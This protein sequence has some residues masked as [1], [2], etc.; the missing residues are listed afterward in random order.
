MEGTAI[1]LSDSPQ[2]IVDVMYWYDCTY[3]SDDIHYIPELLMLATEIVEYLYEQLLEKTTYENI[4]DP[5]SFNRIDEYI[6]NKKYEK[7]M[8]FVDWWKKQEMFCEAIQEN[9]FFC[10]ENNQLQNHPIRKVW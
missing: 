8:P 2:Y 9:F 3:N 6:E 7:E 10:K 5:E 4:S 1:E